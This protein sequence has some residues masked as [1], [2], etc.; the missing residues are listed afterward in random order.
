MFSLCKALL[1]DKEVWKVGVG[2]ERDAEY[3]WESYDINVEGSLDLR[4]VARKTSLPQ[5][6]L[7]EMANNF[8]NVRLK[9]YQ[10]SWT[11]STSDLTKEQIDYAAEDAIAGFE[12]FN[13]FQQRGA[14]RHDQTYL[15]LLDEHF[16]K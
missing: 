8:L 1:G 2:S 5:S 7:K 16:H 6:S 3:L 10:R 11:W 15:P 12:L 4:Y 14:R 13:Y 9:S